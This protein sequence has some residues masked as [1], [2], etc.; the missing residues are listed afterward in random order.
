[1]TKFCGDIDHALLLS[2][3][4]RQDFDPLGLYEACKEIDG[5]PHVPGTFQLAGTRVSSF[6]W[7]F[8][9]QPF[10][11]PLSSYDEIFDVLRLNRFLM[12]DGVQG[13]GWLPVQVAFQ[14]FPS[15]DT[16]PQGRVPLPR[17]GE[18]T[19]GL[20]SVLLTFGCEEAGDWL[21]FINSW[22]RGWGDQ[23]FGLLSR[24]Y[25][26]RYMTDAWVSR[27]ARCGATALTHS[28]WVN[29]RTAAERRRIWMTPNP[30]WRRRFRHRGNGHQ[31]VV[32]KT[33]SVV[34]E[35]PVQVIEVRN[36]FG[37]RLG[38]AHLYHLVQEPRVSV[39]KELYV[40]P[41]FRRRG[42]G[43]I[44]EATAAANARAW[45]AERLHVLF[46]AMD[47]QLSLRAAGRLFGERVGYRW[48]WR[49]QQRPH[50]AAIGEKTF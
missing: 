45:G 8:Q 23:G 49:E 9:R 33:L 20:H 37:V 42:Y 32:Y 5:I 29:A 47:A 2:R 36:G 25:L 13:P 38:W 40:W 19:R 48:R 11:E 35:R 28:R 7:Q 12:S 14:I 15:M 1:M 31:L 27:N 22:G 43:T 34:E 46:H 24:E 16:A 4:L 18:T 6:Y 21:R 26:E 44:L 3:V 10:Y 41:E 50:L 30:R 17:P 39:L